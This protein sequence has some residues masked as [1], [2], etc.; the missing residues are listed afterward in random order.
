MKDIVTMKIGK[1]HLIKIIKNP[2]DY[3]GFKYFG[4]YTKKL[5]GGKNQNGRHRTKKHDRRLEN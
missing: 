5:E 3:N 1:G 2:K 4:I